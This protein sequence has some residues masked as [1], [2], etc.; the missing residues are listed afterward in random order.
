MECRRFSETSHKEAQRKALWRRKQDIFPLWRWKWKTVPTNLSQGQRGMTAPWPFQHKSCKEG[1]NA[2][3]R[4]HGELSFQARKSDF[5]TSTQIHPST[6]TSYCFC[7]HQAHC[8]V[9][10]SRGAR[11]TK[12]HQVEHLSVPSVDSTDRGDRGSLKPRWI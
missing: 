8:A 10:A 3:S 5:Q 11:G 9:T 4:P 6:Q 2:F 1:P 12:R 7:Q